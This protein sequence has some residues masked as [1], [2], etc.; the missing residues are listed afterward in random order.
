MEQNVSA[1]TQNVC[2]PTTRICMIET[3]ATSASG[4]SGL[5]SS[6]DAD[7]ILSRT[8]WRK[9][10]L[11]HFLCE[12]I[13]AGVSTWLKKFWAT[14]NA[15]ASNKPTR[16]HCK[17]GSLSARLVLET[18]AK[19]QDF[20]ARYKDDGITNEVDSIF[21][22]T[23]TKILVRQSNHL[24]IEKLEDDLHHFGKR[25]PQ[26]YKKSSL[27]EMPKVLSLSP[28]LTSVRKS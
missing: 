16:I 19:C 8:R 23:S 21:Y 9:C 27:N 10:F 5:A 6:Q 3:G 25:C 4:G 7:L 20:V 18:R 12:Q 24:K 17:T 28:H 26:S 15:L 2:S 13:H 11:L 22:N 14:T 1:L